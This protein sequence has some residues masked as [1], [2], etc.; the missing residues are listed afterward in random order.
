MYEKLKESE[1]YIFCSNHFNSVCNFMESNNENTHKDYLISVWKQHPLFSNIPMQFWCSCY[2]PTA[3]EIC[4]NCINIRYLFNCLVK[5][6]S[7]REL[8]QYFILT[9][10]HLKEYLKSI[11]NETFFYYSIRDKVIHLTL[12]NPHY[13]CMKNVNN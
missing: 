2:K 6:A 13:D 10:K 12:D 4:Q 3:F 1:V 9:L 11:T 7:L 5:K 8:P